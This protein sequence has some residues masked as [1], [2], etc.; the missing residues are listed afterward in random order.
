MS[1]VMELTTVKLWRTH[2]RAIAAQNQY[3]MR[4]GFIYTGEEAT[5]VRLD[6]V[7][8]IV[9]AEAEKQGQQRDMY[10]SDEAPT[11]YAMHGHAHNKMKD[12]ATQL[13]EANQ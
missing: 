2:P 5:F 6:Q 8:E 4:E 11:H 9:E 1:D 12:L 10:E 3:E 13:K 7:I